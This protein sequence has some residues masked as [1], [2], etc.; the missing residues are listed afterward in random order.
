VLKLQGYTGGLGYL[1]GHRIRK[2]PI[3]CSHDAVKC[4]G[5]GSFGARGGFCGSGFPS[6]SRQRQNTAKTDYKINRFTIFRNHPHLFLHTSNFTRETANGRP[7]PGCKKAEPAPPW[8][9]SGTF[10]FPGSGKD[11][12]EN[13]MEETR[14]VP[15]D[16]G[17]AGEN[18]R[19]IGAVRKAAYGPLKKRSDG[20]SN[21]FC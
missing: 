18:R 1:P 11:M 9:Q 2:G 3:L 20:F 4:K 10:S 15:M 6:A 16:L 14:R 5:D 19:I 8:G 12:G 17:R 21:N 13:D 7:L